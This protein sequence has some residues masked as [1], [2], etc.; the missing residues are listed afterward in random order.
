MSCVQEQEI[1]NMGLKSSRRWSE[2]VVM[3]D[4]LASDTP[5]QSRPGPLGAVAR[6]VRGLSVK[7]V[8]EVQV[9]FD[10]HLLHLGAQRGHGT[11]DV[12]CYG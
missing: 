10:S 3:T 12:V 11:A 2:F 8:T 5:G 1:N 4:Y 9:W 6:S 7:S